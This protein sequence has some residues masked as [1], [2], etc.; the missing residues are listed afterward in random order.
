MSFENKMKEIHTT[1]FT[2]HKKWL[3]YTDRWKEFCYKPMKYIGVTYDDFRK[4]VTKSFRLFILKG[5]F[6][7]TS[8][9]FN[10]QNVLDADPKTKCIVLIYCWLY[11]PSIFSLLNCIMHC[12]FRCFKKV[13]GYRTNGNVTLSISAKKHH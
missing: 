4:I 9:G 8:N 1:S 3:K 2:K 13:F 10:H 7:N 6:W 12:Q 5:L 11:I